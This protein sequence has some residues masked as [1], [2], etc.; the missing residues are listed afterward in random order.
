MNKDYL[1]ANKIGLTSKSRISTLE[2][3]L[4][5]KRM[6]LLSSLYIF[7]HWLRL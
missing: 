3:H 7:Q 6:S 1:E 4:V 5:I 2:E